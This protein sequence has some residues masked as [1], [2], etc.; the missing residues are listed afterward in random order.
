MYTYLNFVNDVK[1]AL[2]NS[3]DLDWY[4]ISEIAPSNQRSNL[5]NWVNEGRLTGQWTVSVEDD[6]K[7]GSGK[8]TVIHRI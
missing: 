2:A 1:A 8:M 4:A 3:P 7:R 5:F 6:T